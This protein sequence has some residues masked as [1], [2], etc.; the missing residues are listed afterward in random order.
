MIGGGVSKHR[1]V[2]CLPDSLMGF[3]IAQAKRTGLGRSHSVRQGLVLLQKSIE[4]ARQ[5]EVENKLRA[6]ALYRE[7]ES[8]VEKTGALS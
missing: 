4:R 1:L 6:E 3:L 8:E 7:I 5:E 2:V